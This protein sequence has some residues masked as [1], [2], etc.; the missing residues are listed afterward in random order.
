MIRRILESQISGELFRGKAIILMGPRQTG[1][2]TLIR[3][4]SDSTN[5]PVKW[6][7]GDESDVRDLF[8]EPTSN[9]LKLM[10]GDARILV[11][12]EAQR[13]RNIG[14]AIKLL[15]DN[16]PELQVIATGSSSFE[17]ANEINEPLTGRKFEHF[18]FPL[19][20][21]EL[22]NHL[23][24]MEE[25]RL[26]NHRIIYGSYP[27]V[28]NNPGREQ[29]V[30]SSL[31]DSYLYK[32]ILV[33]KS[34]KKPQALEKLIK[35]FAL[36]IGSEVSFH[37]LAQLCG[38]D[39]H[40]VENYVDILEKAFIVYKVSGLYRNKR[41]ELK[42]SK[43]IFFYDN[44]IRN[45]V[46]SNFNMPDSRSDTGALWE[47]FFMS[48]RAKFTHYHNIFLNRYFWRSKTKQEI[49]LIEEREGKMFA[50]EIKWNP[51][52]AYR[53]PRTFLENYPDHQTETITPDNYSDFLEPQ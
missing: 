23:G 7:N 34:I 27:E 46:I 28:I 35:A 29:Q 16:Y 50:F 33:W 38:L 13:I 1:K 43:K 4:L 17:L 32:D 14:I 6:L 47:N 8:R 20:F 44:G 49:D 24:M 15:V 10:A 52:S 31:S 2:T 39:S 51:R 18:L 37:E 42:K 9:G 40:T 36:Q 21:T 5:Q 3:S 48:E 12:D 30:L 53:F 19:S 26:L 41:N 11:I 25:K 45:A 22:R